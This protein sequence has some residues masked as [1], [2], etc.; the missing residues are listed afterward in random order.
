M[1]SSV[2]FWATYRRFFYPAFFAWFAYLSFI[3]GCPSSF[4]VCTILSSMTFIKTLSVGKV[5]GSENYKAIIIGAGMSG[6]NTAIKLDELGVE[7]VILE[8][9]KDLGGTWHFNRYPGA[10]CDVASHLYSFSFCLNPW[11]SRLYSTS[12]E[13]R[14]YMKDV[15]EYFGL[16]SKIKFG[17][18]VT[19][20]KWNE[21]EQKWIVTT[22][23]GQTYIGNFLVHGKGVLHYPVVPDFKGK[24]L[25]KGP[26]FHTAEWPDNINL[27]GKKVGI[28]GTGASAVQTIPAIAGDVKSLHVFQRTPCWAPPRLDRAHWTATKIFFS[29][30]P[31][32]MVAYR[33]YLFLFNE[34]FFW[35]DIYVSWLKSKD[36]LEIY[37]ESLTLFRRNHGSSNLRRPKCC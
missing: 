15:A 4:V 32:A 1:E 37:F 16:I 25:F 29:L 21:K 30:F 11:W 23:N 5:K 13:I 9:A 26:S 20:A 10:A 28:I 35:G 17:C 7:Y 3:Y 22:K 18:E 24:D 14:Q 6:M 12:P 31:P 19:N 34:S 33:L 27:K 2:A 36:Q 8:K